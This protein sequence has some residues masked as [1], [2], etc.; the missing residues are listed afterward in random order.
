MRSHDTGMLDDLLADASFRFLKGTEDIATAERMSMDFVLERA[1][2]AFGAAL[3]EM[4][5]ELAGEVPRAW[6]VHE[7]VR[8]RPLAEFGRIEYAQ[9]VYIDEAGER[10][11][12]L[13]EVVGMPAR[14]R[15]TPNAADALAECACSASYADAAD[16]VA[17]HCRARVS[18]ASVAAIVADAGAMLGEESARLADELFERGIDP[19]GSVSAD[20]LVCE[21]DGA[22]VSTRKRGREGGPRRTEIKNFVAYTGKSGGRLQNR[23]AHAGVEKPAS[24]W[25]QSVAA[26][27]L[28]SLGGLSRT[29]LGCD[30]AAWCKSGSDFLPKDT[31]VVLD[32]WH[33]FHNV[34]G[35]FAD[36]G[37]ASA[38]CRIV[39]E[40]GPHALSSWLSLRHAGDERAAALKRYIDSNADIIDMSASLGAIEGENAHVISDRM[41]AWRCAW[42]VA[43][44]DAMARMRAHRANGR[45]LPKRSRGAFYDE[46]RWKRLSA[47][48]DKRMRYDIA[49]IG[50]GYEYPHNVETKK[51]PS[52][53]EHLLTRW[54]SSSIPY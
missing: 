40:H 45:P 48:V 12:Y 35:A 6:R 53:P 44:A 19:G 38:A 24:F 30:G 37:E 18:E 16:L 31:T 33:I 50:E 1:A 2:A 34:K 22:W 28:V 3:T 13:D 52:R 9:T 17:R 7:H 43:G 47:R 49:P 25:R 46:G 5:G 20:V 39:R 10:R 8:R 15:I 4:D 51:L 32:K 23:V 14:V 11:R 54:E 26:G 41:E 27:T 29:Y 36:K 42:S 21:A